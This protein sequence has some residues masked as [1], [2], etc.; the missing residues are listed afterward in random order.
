MRRSSQ[1]E[2]EVEFAVGG[3]EMEMDE[4]CRLG[5][6]VFLT[7]GAQNQLTELSCPHF[8]FAWHWHCALRLHRISRTRQVI[9]AT[10]HLLWAKL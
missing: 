10:L 9:R 2:V 8:P 3:W 7:A 6:R 5:Q 1:L 4:S